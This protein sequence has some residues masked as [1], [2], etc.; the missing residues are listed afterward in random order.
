MGGSLNVGQGS[1]QLHSMVSMMLK[2]CVDDVCLE[3]VLATR[4]FVSM[5][6]WIEGMFVSMMFVSMQM[7]GMFVSMDVLLE[8]VLHSMVL[9]TFTFCCKRG[10]VVGL[11]A[12]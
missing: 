6:F 2:D 5:M 11:R 12:R 9:G 1:L 10:A 4:M 3:D 7:F 8:D